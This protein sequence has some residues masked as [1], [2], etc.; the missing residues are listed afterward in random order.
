MGSGGQAAIAALVKLGNQFAMAES[1][2]RRLEADL[3]ELAT[4]QALGGFGAQ[5]ARPAVGG[6]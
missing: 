3:L 5:V 2:R 6:R 4:Q 1:L